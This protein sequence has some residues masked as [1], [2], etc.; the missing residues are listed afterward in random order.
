MKHLFKKFI[1][2]FRIQLKRKKFDKHLD[3]LATLRPSGVSKGDVLLAYIID[4]FLVKDGQKIPNTHT[5]FWESVQIAKTFLGIGYTVDVIS[6]RNSKFKHQKNYD[7]FVSARTNFQRITEQ[8]NEDCIKIV[9]LDM[10]HWVI[11]NY[12]AYQRCLSVYDRRKA[13][14][15][16][17]KLQDENFAIEYADYGT[18]LGNEFTL[19]TY[20]YANKPLYRVPLPT[21]AT[22]PLFEGKNFDSIKINYLWFGSHGFVH[23]GL[24]LVLEAFAQMPEYNLTVCGPIEKENDFKEVYNKELYHTPN[25]NTIGWVDIDS[26]EFESILKQCI[27]IVY[28][29]CAEGGG[30]SVII[31]MHGGLI[32]IVT[33][34]ASVDVTDEYGFIL[35]KPTLDEIQKTVRYLS[36]LPGK[37][38][39][40]MSNKAREF[41]RTNHTKDVFIKRHREVIEGIIDI[42]NKKKVQ[43]GLKF[44]KRIQKNGNH[45]N[46]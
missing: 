45:A 44:S 39:K 32:P 41:A 19:N 35:N 13:A 8:L 27:G 43:V 28:P 15:K 38:L 14:I 24:D 22:F 25:I 40:S 3:G 29:S 1:E 23:K 26:K 30:G 9:N 6:Y 5:H 2:A 34:E 21:L 33:H 37:K 17:Y 4:P 46:Q 36:G 31:C 10:A 20:R 16:N 42:E 11:N 18:V 7:F 12:A